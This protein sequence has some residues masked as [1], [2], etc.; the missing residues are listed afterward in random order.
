[1][2]CYIDCSDNVYVADYS[3]KC[4]NVYNGDDH[5]FL[6]KIDC[7]CKPCAIAFTPD[8]HLIVGDHVNNCVRVWSTTPEEFLNKLMG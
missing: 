8:N 3:S 2:Y 5:S 6:Y 1:M 7:Y 4:I